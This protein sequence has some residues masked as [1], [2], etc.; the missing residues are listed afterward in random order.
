MTELDWI[1]SGKTIDVRPETGLFEIELII[2]L[3]LNKPFS[4]HIIKT[5][6]YNFER[7]K[8][9]RSRL[10]DP[11]AESNIEPQLPCSNCI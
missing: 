10:I 9:K 11:D 5:Y 4:A 2:K 8:R 3:L 6:C 1:E 7:K